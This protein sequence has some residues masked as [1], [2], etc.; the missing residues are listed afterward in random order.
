MGDALRAMAGHAGHWSRR[1]V[2]L[3]GTFAVIGAACYGSHYADRLRLRR[4]AREVAAGQALPSERVLALLDWVYHNKGFRRNRRYFLLPQ[5]R[6]TPVQVML[7]GGDCADKSRLLSAL[8]REIRIPNTMLMCFS[9][10]GREPSHTVVEARVE[11]GSHM[12]VD[13]VYRLWFPRP[14]S[15]GYYGLLD[16]RADPGI[17]E[18]R[19]DE[20]CAA[21][22]R[23]SPLHSY[24]RQ[25]AVYD[26]ASS[27]NWDRNLLTMIMKKLIEARRG[28]DVYR[29]PRPV[30][31][32]E[33]K[34]FVTAGFVVAAVSC[35]V[36][37]VVFRVRRA[38]CSP[39]LPAGVLA[40]GR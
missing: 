38:E 34:L 30:V 18:R 36:L 37:R 25:S 9:R 12:V 23:R 2:I 5:L 32:E 13:P 1:V 33:P 20:V 26:A 8:L 31:L 16:L 4:V 39:S 22:P 11:G 28:E 27:V 3:G 29:W 40:C 15:G 35:L 7:E 14:G 6:A 21:A 19:L 17:L 24:N 10:A